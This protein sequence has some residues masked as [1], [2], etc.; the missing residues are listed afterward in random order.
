MRNLAILV[1]DASA[2]EFRE[3]KAKFHP[4]LWNLKSNMKISV[5]YVSG[6]PARLHQTFLNAST[7]RFRYTKAWPIQNTFDRIQLM[8][9]NRKP[10]SVLRKDSQLIVDIPEGL[11]YL[12]AEM[13]A[14]YKYLFKMNFDVIFRTTLSTVVNP[15][16]FTHIVE[17]IPSNE[18]FYGGN[19]IN[20]GQ[21][22]FV[23]GS[24]TYLNSKC[25]ELIASLSRDWNHGFL[26]DVA[27]G[28]VLEGK[29]TPIHINSINV[30]STDEV[31]ALTDREVSATPTFR[32]RTHSLPRTDMNV[33][34]AMIKR[35]QEI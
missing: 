2:E 5:F 24:N 19:V 11:R 18:P 16:E 14:T 29:L 33:M 26:D 25:G 15:K 7:N 31:A 23:S 28:R 6:K 10:A 8:P 3:I 27:L 4:Q 22:P 12:G 17:N 34:D 30:S 9:F 1:A 32:C 35:I 13:Q 20:F 21:H